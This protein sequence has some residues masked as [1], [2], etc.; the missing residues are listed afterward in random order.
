M[1][2]PCQTCNNAPDC[3]HRRRRGYDIIHCELYD[4]YAV[5]TERTVNLGPS[6]LVR[7]G[8]RAAEPLSVERLAG[9]C[10]NCGRADGCNLPR[11]AGGVWH[12]QEYT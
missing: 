3:V 9:L 7:S 10:V 11:P 5:P 12:C 2:G 1:K 4:G 8:S 6:A